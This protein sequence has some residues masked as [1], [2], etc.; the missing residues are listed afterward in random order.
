MKKYLLASLYIFA[1]LLIGSFKTSQN[2]R[3]QE[4]Q[5]TPCD[6]AQ[7]SAIAQIPG[8]ELDVFLRAGRQEDAAR[9][10]LYIKSVDGDDCREIGT[11]DA[12]TTIYQKTG[13]ISLPKGTNLLSVFAYVE[14]NVDYSAGASVPQV[15]FAGT[16]KL[17]C[18]L[19]T[20]CKVK[21]QNQDF[22]LAPKKVSLNLDTL[23]VGAL[24]PLSEDIKEVIYSVDGK[25]AYKKPTLEEFNLNYVPDGEHTVARTI[26]LN[27]GQSLS[28]S[29]VVARGLEGGVTYLFISILYGQ[30]SL[31]RYA[32]LLLIAVSAYLL[33][34]Y[35]LKKI[36]AKKRW[37]KQ[38]F[39]DPKE[40]F[41]IS[42]AG[43]RKHLSMDDSFGQIFRRYKH[44]FV[45]LIL[46]MVTIFTVNTFALTTFKVDGVSMSPTF[47]DGSRKVL[48]T[49]PINLGR[50]NNNYYLP[51]RGSIVVIKQDGNNLFDTSSVVEESYVVKRVVA[52]PNERVVIKDGKISVYNKENPKGFEPDF[53]YKWI[54][55]AGGSESF[56]MD[57]TLKEGEIFVVGD[58]RAESIDSRYYG[59]ILTSKVVGRAL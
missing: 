31:I 28:D 56:S 41:D 26:V 42:K 36:I 55:D 1:F 43:G 50:L 5:V 35:I 46:L 21:F 49:L 29:K 8:G 20:G 6:Q 19:V 39:F 23:T 11:T 16:D 22:V 25:P 57:V 38:H 4:Y 10:T 14:N 37:K 51:E 12:K 52:L 44:L 15:V 40:H 54:S 18:D 58:N 34:I 32:A 30:S 48:Y 27:D 17:P 9:T 7:Y 24:L 2:S 59:P 3:A 33:F 13:R 45:S 47:K 53:E